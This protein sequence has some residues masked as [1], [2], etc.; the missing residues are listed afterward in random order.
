M[1]LRM[2]I[3]DFK[4]EECG[5]VEEKMQSYTAPAPECC[6]NKPMVKQVVGTPAFD[7]VG[8]GFHR[9]DYLRTGTRSWRSSSPKGREYD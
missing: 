3:Y 5:K 6:N 2:P 9:N 1:R 4:C 8:K 7:L